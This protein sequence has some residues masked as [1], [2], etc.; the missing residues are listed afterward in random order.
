MEKYDKGEDDEETERMKSF[1]E[2]NGLIEE[3]LK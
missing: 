3:K 1:D 2:T